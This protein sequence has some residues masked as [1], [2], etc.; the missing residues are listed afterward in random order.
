[1]KNEKNGVH[2]P[3]IIQEGNTYYLVS[4]DTT[5]PLTS[6]VPIRS[7]KDLIHWKFEKTALDGVPKE[8]QQW[9]HAKQLWAPDILK[10]GSEY[11]M[12]YSASTFGSTRS[13]IGLA[14]ATDILG[15]WQDQGE[16]VKTNAEIADNNAI[17]ANI[18]FDRKN[19]QW[20][21]YGS[22]F[23]GIY[24]LPIDSHSGKP[25]QEGYGKKIAVRPQSVEGAIEG[26]FIFYHEST[27]CF[28]LFVSFDS[29]ND[30]YNIRVGRSKEIEG[31]YLDYW[32]H[33][34]TDS[35]TDP[36]EVGTKMIGSYQVGEM[37]PLYGPGHNSIFVDKKTQQTFVVHH[38]RRKPFSA[39]FFLQIRPLFWL[40][41]GWPVVGISE[42]DGNIQQIKNV[43]KWSGE[44]E[45]VSF[46]VSSELVYSKKRNVT[47]L[48]ILA[49]EGTYSLDLTK[50]AIVY[51]DK[52]GD[53]LMTGRDTRGQAIMGKKRIS[54]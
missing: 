22:F 7:S 43:D 45:I 10:V 37:P 3:T 6:G 4:T 21:V 15:D 27:D 33:E 1:M 30:S 35:I 32:G 48:G 17:D 18:C 26:P 44:W 49:L 5:Q 42:Y 8:A 36:N 46:N 13:M 2:D 16:I 19:N 52:S 29:L 54:E 28:Y 50:Q 39:D 41:D 53:L 51:Q 11:R 40:E 38:V 25:T 23:G 24:L 47:D 12:Y 34:M 14:T 9:S 20:L 31:P